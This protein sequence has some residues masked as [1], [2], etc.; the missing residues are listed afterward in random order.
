MKELT[1]EEMNTKVEGTVRE[2]D[3]ENEGTIEEVAG[4][5]YD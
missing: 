1:N 5:N 4:M 3:V 2:M